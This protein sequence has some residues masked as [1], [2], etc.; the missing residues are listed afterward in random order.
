MEDKKEEEKKEEQKEQESKK[1]EDKKEE[2]KKEEDKKE[3]VKKEENDKNIKTKTIFIPSNFMEIY[4]KCKL[5]SWIEPK[6]IISSKINYVFDSFLPDV[7]NYFN[8]IEKQK[9]PRLNKKSLF[10]SLSSLSEN[11]Y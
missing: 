8:E 4:N 2:P 10:S 1:E 7:I 11:T 5:V 6:D 9:S 3:E